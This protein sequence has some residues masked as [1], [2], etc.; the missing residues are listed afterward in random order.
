MTEA[1]ASRQV[2][3][4]PDPVPVTLDPATTALFVMDITDV[5]CAPQPNCVAMLPRISALIGKARAA[6]ALVAYTLGGA[7]GTVL[8]EVAPSPNEPVVQGRQNK[9]FGTNLD[10]ITRARGVTTVVLAGWRANGS[11]LFTSH[12]ATLLGYTVVVAV[13][14]T[15]AAQEFE[16]AIGLYQVLNLLDGN[17]KNEPLKPGAVTLSRSDLISFSKANS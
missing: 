16:V 5:T 4:A 10:D 1:G 3:P 9:F 8:S 15:A 2:P 6:G 17:P 12:G 13:D 11:I 14:C 7:G